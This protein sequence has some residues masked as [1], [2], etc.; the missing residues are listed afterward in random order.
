MKITQNKLIVKQK[1]EAI[2]IFTGFE[3]NNRYQVENEIGNVLYY[4]YEEA[5][6]FA[7]QFLGSRRPNKLVIMDANKVPQL[8]LER[9]FYWFN[10][11]YT[12][13]DSNG[14]I[15]AHI[16]QKKWFVNHRKFEIYDDSN[17]L[18]FTCSAKLPHIWT[19]NILIHDNQVAQIL[20]KWSGIGREAFTDADFFNIDF[21][22][23]SDNIKR[24]IILA[25]AFAIDLRV[26]EQKK[27]SA[28]SGMSRRHGR[29]INF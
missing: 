20:K 26:F 22:T 12:V 18:L 7:K 29:R 25:L 1:V 3:T 19:F 13:R 28:F 23:V 24:Q 15:I 27:K 8:T 16:K 10:A 5:G 17:Q 2:E 21:G 9:K 14:N 6:F 11:K 4:A